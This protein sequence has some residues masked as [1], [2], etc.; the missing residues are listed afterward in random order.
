M[1]YYPGQTYI[2]SIGT[3]LILSARHPDEHIPYPIYTVSNGYE[4]LSV[5]EDLIDE[6]IENRED[7]KW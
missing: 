4:D 3:I 2:T 1:K 6:W 7:K 5:S